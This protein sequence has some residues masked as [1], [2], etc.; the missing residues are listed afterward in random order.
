MAGKKATKKNKITVGLIRGN[1]ISNT[2]KPDVE[3][4]KRQVAE[5]EKV[6]ERLNPALLIS[7]LDH[8]EN[9]EYGDTI[10]RLSP[11]ARVE[12]GDYKKLQSDLPKRVYVKK[13]KIKKKK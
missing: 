7:G 6:D 9:I 10:I 1:H 5:G 13:I 2:T 12:I 11:R 8:P 3:L 4:F